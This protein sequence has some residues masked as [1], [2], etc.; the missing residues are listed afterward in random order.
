LTRT[1]FA[2]L[3]LFAPLCANDWMDSVVEKEFARWEE[4]GITKEMVAKTWAACCT[5][6]KH[7]YR[8]YQVRSGAIDGQEGTFKELLTEIR[9]R[10]PLPDL[11]IIYY[12]HDKVK[13]GFFQGWD[14]D[15][16]NAPI[17]VSAKNKDLDRVVLFVDYFYHA[18][19]DNGGWHGLIHRLN[20]MQKR[21]PWEEKTEQLFWRGSSTDGFYTKESWQSIPRGSLVHLGTHVRPDLIDAALVNVFPWHT[22]DMEW[23]ENTFRMDRFASPVR[24]LAYKYQMIMDGVTCTYPG[25]QWR[26][27]SGCLSFKQ[28]T[29]DVMWFFEPLIPWK[30]YVP[31]KKDLSDLVEKI[32]WAKEHDDE[33]RAIAQN[34]REFAL[35]NLMKEEILLYCYKALCKYAQLQKQ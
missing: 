13:A 34:A 33:A 6:K 25:T 15:E 12:H 29:D 17:L 24:H 7:L 10:Y 2:F 1:L 4:T 23:L 35:N 27:L 14:P 16:Q 20:K 11:D 26:L 32:L 3:L 21:Y 28:Q 18:Q 31:V 30:H 9:K 19:D 8:R 22:D 5:R